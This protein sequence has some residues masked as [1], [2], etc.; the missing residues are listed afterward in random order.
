MVVPLAPA[1]RPKSTLGWPTAPTPSRLGPQ[2]PRAIPMLHR[3]AVPGR[4]DASQSPV[5]IELLFCGTN[6]G[7]GQLRAPVLLLALYSPECVE[8][9]FSEVRRHG[10]LEHFAERVSL[11]GIEVSG[12]RPQ[13]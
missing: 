7:P 6:Q 12:I 9:R 11:R 4:S 1:P 13:A 5:L 8:G 2:T 3:P 10:V